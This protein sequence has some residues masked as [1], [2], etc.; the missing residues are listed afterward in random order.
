MHIFNAP[1]A[2][3]MKSGSSVLNYYFNPPYQAFY[4]NR[5]CHIGL[6]TRLINADSKSTQIKGSMHHFPILTRTRFQNFSDENHGI[7]CSHGITGNRK[8]NPNLI[9]TS[10]LEQTTNRESDTVSGICMYQQ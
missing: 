8:K 5:N 1:P 3:G 10:F 4:N 7:E 2:H 6:K 9:F